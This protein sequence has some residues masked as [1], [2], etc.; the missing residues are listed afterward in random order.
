VAEE[1]D[2]EV[3]LRTEEA[4]RSEMNLTNVIVLSRVQRVF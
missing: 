4:R 2:A 1:F 3:V